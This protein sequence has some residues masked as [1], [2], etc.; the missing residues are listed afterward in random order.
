MLRVLLAAE[1]AHLTASAVER[2]LRSV[3]GDVTS[4]AI[5]AVVRRRLVCA[6]APLAGMCLEDLEQ[7][8]AA[9]AGDAA[10]AAAATVGPPVLVRHQIARSWSHVS[11]LAE[12][13]DVLVIPGPTPRACR[14]GAIPVVA[15]T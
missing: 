6:W 10:R 4:I 2:A 12:D 15:L 3:D 9:H 1:P 11:K 7:G 13:Y 5:T 8:M 14:G